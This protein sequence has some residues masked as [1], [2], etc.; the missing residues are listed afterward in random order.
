MKF[1]FRMTMVVFC[2]CL[3]ACTVVKPWQRGTLAKPEMAWS[4][5]SLEAEFEQHVFSSKEASHGGDGAAGGG[6]GC[7]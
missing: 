5:D 4:K 3:S 1:Y 7:N 6:C 2:L